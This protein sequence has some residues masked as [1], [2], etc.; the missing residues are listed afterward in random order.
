[1]QKKFLTVIISFLN[2]G[3]EVKR[4]I[5]SVLM[6]AEDKVEIIVI[7]DGSNMLY[8]YEEMLLPFNITYI[9]NSIRRGTA[10]C[11]DLGVQLAQTPYFILLDAH[12]RFYEKGW[13]DKIVSYLKQDDRRLLCCQTRA[14][15][16]DE[17]DEIVLYPERKISYGA[18]INF[19]R[20]EKILTPKWIYEE[21]K[22]PN[23][24]IEDIP[25]VLGASYAASKR[26]WGYLRGLEGLMFYGYEEPYISMKVWMEGG[27]CQLVKDIEIGHIY[28]TSFPYRVANDEMMYNRLWI[29][30]VILP[31]YWKE[32]VYQASKK[33][34]KYIFN[35]IMSRINQ[36]H[37]NINEMR[38]Y[39]Q[40]IFTKDFSIIERLNLKND[41]EKD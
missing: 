32:Q 7:N 12:M 4:T 24:T 38:I 14:L 31:Q 20:K 36:L 13:V 17:S 9:K 19:Q 39:Y 15:M 3:L 16:K 10:A 40:S 23:Q 30:T 25:C 6:Y 29:A 22:A 18:Y 1:M 28:R 37:K 26:Y 41:Y 27:R 5:E 21:Q 8:D 34:D 33:Q 11:R 2:E 35:H